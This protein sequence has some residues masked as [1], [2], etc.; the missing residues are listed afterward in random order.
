MRTGCADYSSLIRPLVRHIHRGELRAI[1]GCRVGTLRYRS[2]CIWGADPPWLVRVSASGHLFLD[3]IGDLP[4]SSQAALLRTLE[5]GVI[6]PVGSESCQHVDIRLVCA[7]H[8]PLRKMVSQHEFREDLY[9][10][11]STLTLEVPP[12]RQRIEDMP[13]LL[14]AFFGDRLSINSKRLALHRI[15]FMARKCAGFVMC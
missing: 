1:P 8:R 6:W 3:E 10:R 15:L 11:I 9:H 13:L 5:N 2:W 7:T 4:L 14:Q 12:L